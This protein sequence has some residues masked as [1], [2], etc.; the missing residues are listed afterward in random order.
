MLAS[1]TAHFFPL[2]NVLTLRNFLCGCHSDFTLRCYFLPSVKKG[3]FCL[4]G[5]KFSSM[6]GERGTPM[7]KR[8]ICILTVAA[9]AMACLFVG[10]FAQSNAP[11]YQLLRTIE[12]PGGLAAFDISWV[13]ASSQILPIG[14]HGDPGHGPH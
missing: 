7:N 2:V 3:R 5:N 1:T 6:R 13:D 8:T 9:A 4:G 10:A 14:S 11:N 12:V